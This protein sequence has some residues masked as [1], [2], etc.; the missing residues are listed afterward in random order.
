MPARWNS[1]NDKMDRAVLQLRIVIVAV[2]G[3]L[4]IAPAQAADRGPRCPEDRPCVALV[5]GG[6]GARGGAHIGVMQALEEQG[7][8]VDLV[9]G[10]S[11][12]ALLGSMYASG[13]SSETIL[14]RYQAATWNDGFH[15]N[16]PRSDIPNRRKR[17]LD[18][19]PIHLDLGV[20]LDGLKLPKGLIQ[21]QSMKRLVDAALAAPLELTS[22]DD[23]PIAF[24]AVAAD[25][26]TGEPVVLAGGDLSTAVQ[27]SMSLPGIV[28]PV[29][30]QGRMLVDGG[31]AENLPVRVALDYGADLIIAVDIGS[32]GLE[33]EDQLESA[34]VIMKQLTGFLTQSN[35]RASR[36]LLREHDLLVQPRI[37]NVTLL[38]FDKLPDAVEAGYQAGQAAIS[39]SPEWLALSGLGAGRASVAFRD[40]ERPYHADKIELQNNSRLSDDYILHRMNLSEGESYS[41]TEI[42]KGMDRL[43]G[44]GTIARVIT[45]RA[46]ENDEELLR[47]RVDEKEWGPGYMDFKL[48][49]EDDLHSFS[50]YQVGFS[51]RLTNLSRYGAEWYSTVE[52]G[53]EKRLHT[54]L[55]WPLGLT[56]FYLDAAIDIERDI[57][58][59]TVEG[60]SLGVVEVRDATFA[61]GLGWTPV[62]RFDL[63]LRT[64][65]SDSSVELPVLIKE[66]LG[67][68]RLDL[69]RTGAGLSLN[70]DS[71]DDASFPSRG[72]KFQ[73]VF[74]RTLD[75]ALEQS[76]YT[77]QIDSEL[78]GVLSFGRHQWRGQLRAQS[79][80]NDDPASITGLFSLGG[81]L[82]LS[83]MA[84]DS[85]S[86]Q[87]VRFGSVVYNY[88]LKKNDFG[89]LTLPVYL[90]LSAE[91]GNA[92]SDS[93]EID[94]TDLIHSGSAYIG[95]DSPIGPAYFAYGRASN[96]EQSLYAFLGIVF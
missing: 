82:N 79:T 14:E 89:A 86:G 72:W 71:L 22:F 44:Q 31:I 65:A 48:S 93:E 58:D 35:V 76:D 37:D 17:Q 51:Y 7:I 36:D 90:G 40:D 91:A 55:Y 50:H 84:K 92:W 64:I 34:L 63:G 1:I 74:T 69:S 45:A 59:Y 5:L 9:V 60:D 3:L 88:K 15:D 6:G 13:M 62:D 85:L 87:Q 20:G 21:G 83:G 28:R 43:Y 32:P 77:N 47:V 56:P 67:I 49:F 68:D 11:A 70:Y 12:G 30:W 57:F 39:T 73:S 33:E 10:T 25:A 23:L 52:F 26:V 80:V 78:I 38:S 2:L 24:R 19:F 29:E 41:Q 27:A 8:P 18:T 95:W 94:Y 61:G 54:E 53:T 96:G 16:I 42:Q 81:F 4:T 75:E 66:L 46:Q